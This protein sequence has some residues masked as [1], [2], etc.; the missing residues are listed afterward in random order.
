MG[1]GDYD[2]NGVYGASSDDIE[3]IVTSN[4]QTCPNFFATVKEESGGELQQEVRWKN[5]TATSTSNI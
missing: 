2:E 5:N 1:Y 3:C 4:N